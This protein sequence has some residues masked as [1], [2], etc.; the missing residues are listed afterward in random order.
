MNIAWLDIETTGL[1]QFDDRILEVGIV[2]TTPGPDFLPVVYNNWVF[3]F[4]IDDALFVIPEVVVEMHNKN[5]LWDEC[6]NAWIEMV[7]PGELEQEMIQFLVDNEADSSVMYGNT[8]HFDRAF[9]ARHLAKLHEQF[10][11][12]NFDVSTLKQYALMFN[13]EYPWIDREIHRGVPDCQDAIAN[14]I[15]FRNVFKPQ[16]PIDKDES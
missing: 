10:H 4:L 2:I 1:D 5:E 6:R 3:P 7:D 8:V 14:A 12:R 9:L 15:H 11:Y 16:W 13:K